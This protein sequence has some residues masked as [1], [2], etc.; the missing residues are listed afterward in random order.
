MAKKSELLL[1]AKTSVQS[2]FSDIFQC[3]FR[4]QLSLMTIFDD[5]LGATIGNDYFRLFA[6]IA[7]VRA[8][9]DRRQCIAQG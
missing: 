1:F 3:F 8:N 7:I 9:D 5:F 2:S 4:A 6:T